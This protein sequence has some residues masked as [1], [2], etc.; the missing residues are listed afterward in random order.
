VR[1]AIVA[2]VA[3]NGVIGRDQQLPWQLPADLQHFKAVTIGKPILMGRRTFASI[4]RAL[5]G[6]RNLL[7]T[8]TVERVPVAGIEVVRTLDEAIDRCAGVEE[9]CVIG[10]AEVYR[11][12]LPRATRL[13]LT[14]VHADVAGD[15]LFPPLDLRDWQEV[16][17]SEHPA[18]ARHEYSMSFTTLERRP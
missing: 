16:A 8:R 13:Y 9:L 14:R 4:G 2:A 15:V 12:A 1:L 17:R 5:P 7:L 3:A 6:R 10:G 11:A 18:D